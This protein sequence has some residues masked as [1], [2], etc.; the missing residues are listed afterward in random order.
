MDKLP[1]KLMLAALGVAALLSGCVA[2]A[3]QLDGRFG[4]AMNAAKAQQTLNPDAG[5]NTKPA[6]GMDGKAAAAAVDKY[7]KSFEKEAV[8]TN[9]FTIGVGK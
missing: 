4:D 8:T 7:H 1:L 5:M 9:V 3:P 6:M 2:P